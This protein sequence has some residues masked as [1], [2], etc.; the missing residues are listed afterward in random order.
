MALLCQP[1]QRSPSVRPSRRVETPISQYG[2]IFSVW[3]FPALHSAI[4][5]WLALR[6]LLSMQLVST[7]MQWWDGGHH[8]FFSMM[9]LQQVRAEWASGAQPLGTWP[10]P[11]AGACECNNWIVSKHGYLREE[12]PWRC[13]VSRLNAHRLRDLV[14]GLRPQLHRTLLS[15]RFGLSPLFTAQYSVGLLCAHSF[16]CSWCRP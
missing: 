16:Q 6:S 8:F 10:N 9:V 11:V 13:S 14:A 1:T 5:S 4:L 2:S 7:L 3:A 15:S 12:R